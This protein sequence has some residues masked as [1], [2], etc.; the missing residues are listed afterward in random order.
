MKILE[1]IWKYKQFIFGVIFI[2]TIVL[3]FNQCEQTKKAKQKLKDT[4]F[5]AN[6]NMQALSDN[7]IQLKLTLDQLKFVDKSLYQATL[8]IDS[9][10][11]IK[12]KVITKTE[13]QYLEKDISIENTLIYDS[14]RES[15]GL[16]FNNKDNLRT[17]TGTSF[18]KIKNK[19]NEVKIE[20]DSTIIKTFGVR[21]ALVLSEY[22]DDINKYTR[23]KIT[24]F[25]L[26]ETNVLEGPI[27]ESLMKISYRNAELL[28]RPYTFNND[29]PPTQTGSLKIKR[30][31]A[32]TI[33]PFAFGL[34]PVQSGGYNI[35]WIPN[36]G[37]GYYITIQK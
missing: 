20:S 32:L 12:S 10:E 23:I 13:I 30:G 22:Q 7:T 17:F 26:S 11:K 33:N 27:S 15:Y 34:Y 31:F 29:N 21:F 9:L 18:F 3:F 1:Q 37:V 35:G 24:P 19:N 2:L 5:I 6:Q 16:K 4:E 36:I 14:L 8:K 25:Y 28:D